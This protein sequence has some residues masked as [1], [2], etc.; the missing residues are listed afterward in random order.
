IVHCDLKPQNFLVVGGRIKLADFGLAGH[1]T[2]GGGKHNN[3]RRTD[4]AGT[5]RYMPP[6]AFYLGAAGSCD[7]SSRMRPTVDVYAL[8]VI[9]YTMLYFVSPYEELQKWGASRA[10]FAI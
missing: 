1:C 4:W 5:L 2:E 3:S 7:A 10:L 9:L 6:E 8:G